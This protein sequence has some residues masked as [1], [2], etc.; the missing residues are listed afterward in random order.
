V[1]ASGV[2][3]VSNQRR[4]KAVYRALDPVRLLHQLETLQEAL[5]RGQIVKA[6]IV[7]AA[8]HESSPALAGEFQEH[9]KRLTR[10]TST[11]SKSSSSTNCPLRSAVKSGA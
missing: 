2:L 4:L 7:L 11:R 3:D 8:G 6:F 10:H 1:L 5:W 9:V